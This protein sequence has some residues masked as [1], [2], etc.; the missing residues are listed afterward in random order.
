MSHNT[1]AL[2]VAEDDQAQFEVSLSISHQEKNSCFRH[3][4]RFMKILTFLHII[5][6][7]GLLMCF[8]GTAI[9]FPTLSVCSRGGEATLLLFLFANLLSVLAYAGHLRDHAQLDSTLPKRSRVLFFIQLPLIPLLLVAPYAPG[10]FCRYT[11]TDLLPAAI[12]SSVLFVEI[13]F[14]FCYFRRLE[15]Y[16]LHQ[17]MY[18]QKME[19]DLKL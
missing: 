2:T 12:K 8:I 4:F 14:A 7:I 13:L 11:Q 17:E 18:P 10:L 1:S 5:I 6:S 15:V 16:R 9:H 3:H 19:V